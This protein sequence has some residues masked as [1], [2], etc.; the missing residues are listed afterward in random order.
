MVFLN[1]G[2][3]LFF[4][5]ILRYLHLEDSKSILLKKGDK[6]YD[7]LYKV[8]FLVDHLVAV[9][10]QYYYPSRYLNID[11]M[12]RGTRCHV[13]FLQYLP[14]KPIKFGIKIWLNSV[15]KTG[16]VVNFEIYTGKGTA[17]KDKGLGYC[18]VMN[19]MKPYYYKGHCLFVYNFYSSV[20][21]FVDLLAKGVYCTG[22]AHTNRKYFPVELIPEDKS[23]VHIGSFR[24][25]TGKCSITEDKTTYEEAISQVESRESSQKNIQESSQKKSKESWKNSQVGSQKSQEGSQKKTQEVSQKKSHKGSQKTQEVSQKKSH[26]EP[27][28]RHQ[29]ERPGG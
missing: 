15:A 19:L 5:Y 6:G 20:K 14:K 23:E 4:L 10:T 8:H 3:R 1:H 21:L 11:K 25:A 7:P 13:S 28:G 16:Y 26:E 27:G 24:F 18:V 2:Q 12:M 9:Y 22:T 29:E 17:A